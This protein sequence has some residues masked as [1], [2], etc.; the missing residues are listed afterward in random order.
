MDGFPEV[1]DDQTDILQ[2]DFDKK[3]D[4]EL[5]PNPRLSIFAGLRL[6]ESDANN[7]S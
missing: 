5:E 6:D 3:V 7:N 4:K 1:S 2:P